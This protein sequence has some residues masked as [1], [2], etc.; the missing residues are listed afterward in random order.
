[1]NMKLDAI[2]QQQAQKS[3]LVSGDNSLNYAEFLQQVSGYKKSLTELSATSVAICLDNGIDWVLIDIACQQLD[4]VLLPLPTYFSTEQVQH[5]LITAGCDVLIADALFADKFIERLPEA[6]LIESASDMSLYSLPYARLAEDKKCIPDRT[7]KITFT[8][9]TTGQPKGACLS[10][11]HQWQVAEILAKNITSKITK[12]LCVLP[13][14]TLLE[15]IAGIYAPLLNGATV[16]IPTLSSLGFNGSSSLNFN[17]FIQQ[18]SQSEPSSLIT[19]PE[20]LKGLVQACEMGWQAP[21]SLQFI[22]V[23][24]A[25]TAP[26]LLSA[27]KASGLPVF[28]GYGL[29]ECCSVVS[30][31]TINN[32]QPKSA[33]KILS[34]LKV[35][36]EQ[37]EI[38]VQGPLFLG[39]AGDKGSWGK[40]EYATGD[41]GYLDDDGYLIIQG[42]KK[43]TLVTS[44]GRNVN[45]EWI[46]SRLLAQTHIK[47]AIVFGD[48]KPFCCAAIYIDKN[49]TPFEQVSKNIKELNKTLPDYAQIKAY[50]YLKTAILSNS[51][52]MTANGRI[53][54]PAA[55]ANFAE[56]LDDIYQP[57][58]IN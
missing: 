29:S 27:A 41:L 32:N 49:T 58:L 7:A 17:K 19:T 39:Y 50:F 22:A 3:M 24:G 18:I 9:G 25:H 46:E 4:I 36:I 14:A 16:E 5:S 38:I 15:N 48:A 31:N 28:Q 8:S 40:T 1:M 11:A 13:L 42:R 56:Q 55:L 57:E 33:G 53:R 43:N 51:E 54:R 10:N 45:P 47:Q 6:D 26:T 52:L 35:K 44:F 12:H 20:I 23:G 37:N 34:H 2:W 30:L 21:K